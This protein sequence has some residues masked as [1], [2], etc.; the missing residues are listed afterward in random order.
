MKADKIVIVIAAILLASLF[1]AILIFQNIQ[2]GLLVII[3]ILSF[4][5]CLLRIE[6]VFVLLIFAILFSPEFRLFSL[7]SFSKVVYIR[8]EDLLILIGF[9]GMV[10][11][12]AI[13]S[14]PIFRKAPLNV[15]IITFLGIY[16]IATL[17][18]VFVGA[19]PSLSSLFLIL[20]MI[21]FA[22][23]YFIIV[24]YLENEKQG[25]LILSM[26]FIV[27][28]L[29]IAYYFPQVFR[30]SM[31]RG[32]RITSPFEGK[33]EP[34]T[35]GGILILIMGMSFSLLLFE[36]NKNKKILY[37][38][39]LLLS[40]IPFLF[41]L[42]RTSY[43]AAFIAIIFFAFFTRKKWILLL[44]PL[45]AGLAP[46]VLPAV[47]WARV[48]YTWT[49]RSNAIFDSSTM[50]RILI[51]KKIWQPLIRSPF[52]GYGA[53]YFSIIDSCYARIIIESGLLG[54]AAFLWIFVRLYKMTLLSRYKLN[55]VNWLNESSFFEKSVD[56]C[57]SKDWSGSFSNWLI[58]KTCRIV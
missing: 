49:Y 55:K 7:P 25:R 23:F 43:F 44:I 15:P 51:W 38:S 28:F 50:E 58:L 36:K 24:S 3:C 45:I 19:I 6:F 32:I 26:F 30:T 42:S 11:K 33:P 56:C 53:G 12:R 46:I 21:E 34:T 4:L 39:C 5:L 8:L 29:I 27:A 20:K 14:K 13:Q 52:L 47:I 40:F 2:V 9:L 37:G 22:L 31:E 54:F 48:S 57:E 41:S 10:A 16:T 17:R 1:A 35:V 18:G